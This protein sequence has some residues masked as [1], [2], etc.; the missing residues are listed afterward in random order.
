MKDFSPCWPTHYGMGH[1]FVA[2]AFSP[3]FI[4]NGLY[5]LQEV[6][7]RP[8]GTFYFYKIFLQEWKCV[9]P[10]HVRVRKVNQVTGKFVSEQHCVS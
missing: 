5:V 9:S 8:L 10:Y 7:N 1:Y 2:N 6:L 4:E 3:H